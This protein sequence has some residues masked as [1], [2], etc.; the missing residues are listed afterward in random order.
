MLAWIR[1]HYGLGCKATVGVGS[2]ALYRPGCRATL[3]QGV[4]PPW[5]MGLGRP[6][7][8]SYTA[9]WWRL[10]MD[11]YVPCVALGGIIPRLSMASY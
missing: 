2:R 5:P 10:S 9:P 6:T 1:G 11:G 7:V 8:A 4:T 3:G